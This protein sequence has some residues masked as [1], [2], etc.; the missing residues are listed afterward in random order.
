VRDLLALLL[1]HVSER[2]CHPAAPASMTIVLNRR[3][4]RAAR[5]SRGAPCLSCSARRTA[6]LATM[7]VAAPAMPHASCVNPI[8]A[9]PSIEENMPWPCKRAANRREMAD[10]T[11]EVLLECVP[12]QEMSRRRSDTSTR[13]AEADLPH[14]ENTNP[15]FEMEIRRPKCRFDGRK[16][17][18]TQNKIAPSLHGEDCAVRVVVP[19]PEL[20]RC[21]SQIASRTC[22][23][24]CRRPKW[25]AVRVFF[26]PGAKIAAR[27]ARKSHPL[28]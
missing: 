22:Q 21:E 16:A 19:S 12:Q 24:R 2:E 14:A 7:V 6:A 28:E 4:R 10:I 3:S 27:R 13:D 18:S 26:A 15:T 17:D 25:P 11:H 8:P 23:M 5:G 9:P 20:V 1:Q